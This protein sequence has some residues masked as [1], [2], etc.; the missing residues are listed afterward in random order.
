MPSMPCCGLASTTRLRN[1]EVDA[2]VPP[3]QPGVSLQRRIGQIALARD[4]PDTIR[5]HVAAHMSSRDTGGAA[6]RRIKAE[7]CQQCGPTCEADALWKEATLKRR[8]ASGCRV[9]C[10]ETANARLSWLKI[11]GW[12]RKSLCPHHA[13]NQSRVSKR[14]HEGAG[15]R[16]HHD[17]GA[18]SARCPVAD[19][20]RCALAV[21]AQSGTADHLWSPPCRHWVVSQQ[22]TYRLYEDQ[23]GHRKCAGGPRTI[24]WAAAP[25]RL[26]SRRGAPISGRRH[27]AGTSRSRGGLSV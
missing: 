24:S 27:G 4:L 2:L 7:R 3:G 16:K 19:N 25:D 9:S 18:R 13:E 20:R 6:H 5:A 11:A 17:A 15:C 10:V 12:C 14:R 22:H 21:R 26:R 23:R 1:Q 8:G